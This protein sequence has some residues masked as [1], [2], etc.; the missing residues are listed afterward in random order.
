MSSGATT[1][2]LSFLKSGGRLC[3]RRRHLTFPAR[4]RAG[5]SDFELANWEEKMNLDRRRLLKIMSRGMLA[6]AASTALPRPGFAQQKLRVG[7]V[8]KVMGISY[9]DVTRDG[10]R[11]AADELGDVELIYTG[12][13]AATVEQQI[14]VIDSLIAQKIDALI[15]SANDATA[16]IPT[17]KKAM[18]RGIKV[19]SFDSAIAQEGRIM[20]VNAPHDDLIGANDVRMISKTLG[21]EGEVAILSATSQATNQ[22]L[23]IEKMKEEWQKPEYAKLKLVG[24]VYG[25]DA[26]DKSYSEAQGLMKAHPNLRGII[27]PT[28]VGIVAAS[29]AVTDAGKIGNIFVTGHGLPSE[30]KPNVISGVTDTFQLWSPADLGYAAVMYATM[31]ARGQTDGAANSTAKIG[32]LG[33]MTIEA[34]NNT[35]LKDLLVFD[36]S[37]IEEYATQF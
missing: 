29:R 1:A 26:A 10:G 35:Y 20:H 27:S 28:A 15:I 19:I 21:G 30:M 22:N 5:I 8:V 16:L 7:L 3:D 13:T 24:V 6:G 36:K 14:A 37:N 25:D 9:F 23:W 12:P 18:Q 33:D 34:D 4:G 17:G 2:T 32:R 31:I 11:Q